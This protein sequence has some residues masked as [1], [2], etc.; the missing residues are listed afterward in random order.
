MVQNKVKANGGACNLTLD[1]SHNPTSNVVGPVNLIG[2]TFFKQIKI[3]LNGNIISD[4]IFSGDRYP[5]RAYLEMEL[6][7]VCDAKLTNVTAAGYTFENDDV[8]DIKKKKGTL[9]QKQW[10]RWQQ[11]FTRRGM[12]N[13]ILKK[14]FKKKYT[15]VFGCR[16]INGSGA[17]TPCI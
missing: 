8:L 5:C 1:A 3:Y 17:K 13:E 10:Q 11:I 4:S 14:H 16:F 12:K 2:K 6:N 15:T 7:H 9:T